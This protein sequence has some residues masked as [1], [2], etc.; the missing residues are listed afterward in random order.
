MGLNWGNC[1]IPGYQ[2]DINHLILDTVEIF[3]DTWDTG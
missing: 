2:N 3:L 1:Q